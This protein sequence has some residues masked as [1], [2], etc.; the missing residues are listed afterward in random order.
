MAG[1]VHIVYYFL[2]F[3]SKNYIRICDPNNPLWF[4]YHHFAGP[5]YTWNHKKFLQYSR[6]DDKDN[7][8]FPK[9]QNSDIKEIN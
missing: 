3:I 5:F 4:P 6:T 9:L 2:L 7:L 8:I 1:Y